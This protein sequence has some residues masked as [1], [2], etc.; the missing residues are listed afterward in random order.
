M[1]VRPI[2]G[3]VFCLEDIYEQLRHENGTNFEKPTAIE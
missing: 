2:A 3:D 1:N